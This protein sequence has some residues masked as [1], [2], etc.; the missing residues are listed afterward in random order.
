MRAAAQPT[1]PA[2]L[3]T[4]PATLPAAPTAATLPRPVAVDALPLQLGTRVR[5]TGL[6]AKPHLNGQ[7]GEVVG[8]PSAAG[9]LPVVVDG[10][11]EAISVLPKNLE[12]L[13]SRAPSVYDVDEVRG[14]SGTSERATRVSP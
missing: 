12:A 11:A 8:Q 14:A 7:L 5:V 4:L 10:A 9:R 6:K 2:A 1:L 13:A 3:P